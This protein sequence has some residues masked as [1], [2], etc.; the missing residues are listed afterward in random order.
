MYINNNSLKNV[1]SIGTYAF[2]WCENFKCVDDNTGEETPLIFDSI[3]DINTG[4]FQNCTQ[5]TKVNIND[6]ITEIKKS[7][8][9]GCINLTSVSISTE[10]K[11]NK[12]NS[13]AFKGCEKLTNLYMPK[14]LTTIGDSAFEDC[15][16]FLGNTQ[17]QMGA[18]ASY[19][20]VL[21]ETV[22]SIGSSCFKNTKI[23]LLTISNG[24]KTIPDSAFSGC[25]LPFF[26]IS[27]A[28]D[29]IEIGSKAFYNCEFLCASGGTLTLPKNIQTIGD[30]AFE[31][32]KSIKQISLP[33]SLKRLGH[34]CL[35]TNMANTV[36]TIN[37][38]LSSPPVFTTSGKESTT[39]LPLGDIAATP[40]TIPSIS[41]HYSLINKYMY[42]NYWKKYARRMTSFS[43]DDDNNTTPD[44]NPT[45]PEISYD[46]K[47]ILVN[48]A[49]CPSDIMCEIQSTAGM[50]GVINSS[51][52]VGQI[53]HITSA[54][55][56]IVF[57]I[58]LTATGNAYRYADITFTNGT[59]TTVDVQNQ[60]LYA[61]NTIGNNQW[62]GRTTLAVS[63]PSNTVNAAGA[64]TIT[65]H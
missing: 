12:I 64:I 63:R 43:D 38:E 18:P 30:S 16:E 17:L 56:S 4:V 49:Q 62:V 13:S 25:L 46:L 6:N 50:L 27:S 54:S 24:L 26:N 53:S 55:T 31:G 60:S 5:L 32:C 15:K 59:S 42:D 1:T 34:L 58:I 36:I 21:P 11:L 40:S 2:S 33:S 8:F 14:S 29:I 57:T 22:T 35:S 7:A 19:S 3:T 65:I 10:S 47:V 9:E 41:V 20:F 39:S 23:T 52:A 28:N 51:S 44:D 45:T 48:G 37:K 61:N